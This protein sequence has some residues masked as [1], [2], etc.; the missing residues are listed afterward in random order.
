M[1]LHQ[2]KEMSLQ[3]KL[4]NIQ[5]ELKNTLDIHAGRAA[6]G[7]VLYFLLCLFSVYILSLFSEVAL[8]LK[9]CQER[10]TMKETLA[11]ERIK[12]LT[13]EKD[14]LLELSMQRGKIIQASHVMNIKRII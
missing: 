6:F 4:H 2:S 12:A 13:K 1:D 8:K 14:K 9:V 5:K 7:S 10:E 11:E 3:D